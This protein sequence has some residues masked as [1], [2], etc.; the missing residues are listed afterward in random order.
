MSTKVLD[1]FLGLAPF[2]K[3]ISRH[4]RSVRRWLDQPGGLPYTKIGNRILIHVPTARE[5]LL[6]RMENISRKQPR[7][8]IPRATKQK[9]K[10]TK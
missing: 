9:T 5:W 10:T 7:K 2:A 1:D 8:Q 3:Q 6:H 4:P